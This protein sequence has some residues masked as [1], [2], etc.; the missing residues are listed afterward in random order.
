MCVLEM[1]EAL[2]AVPLMRKPRVL[3]ILGRGLYESDS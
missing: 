3:L 2:T 1:F